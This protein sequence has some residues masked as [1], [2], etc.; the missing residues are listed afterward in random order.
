MA[1][2]HSTLS[3]QLIAGQHGALLI[4]HID[5]QGRCC[6]DGGG[7]SRRKSHAGQGGGESLCCLLCKRILGAT[8]IFFRYLDLGNG[9]DA[10]VLT[11]ICDGML[12]CFNV[13]E[14]IRGGGERGQSTIYVFNRNLVSGQGLQANLGIAAQSKG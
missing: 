8:Q 12:A 11:C 14:H 3:G 7:R 10:A 2:A 13:I 5:R 1:L 4:H 6:G 9:K